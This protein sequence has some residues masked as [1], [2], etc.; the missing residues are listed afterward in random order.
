MAERFDVIV[1]GS[2]VNELT[3]ACYLAKAG[4]RVLVLDPRPEIGGVAAFQEI[5]PGFRLEVS[6]SSSGWFW[7]KIAKDLD[8]AV[9]QEWSDPTVVSLN[10]N[11]EPLVLWREM[12]RSRDEIKKHSPADAGKWDAFCALM[13]RLAGFLENLYTQSPPRLMSS[14]AVDLLMLVRLGYRLRQLGKVDMIELL[15]TLPMSAQDL[16]DHWFESELLKGTLGATG[17]TNTFQG[18]RSG[19]TCFV[20]LH[21]LVGRPAGAFRARTVLKSETGHLPSVLANAANRLGVEVRTGVAAKIAIEDGA[22]TGVVLDSGETIAARTV[23]SGADPRKTFLELCDPT[24]LGPEF[25]RAVKNVKMRGVRAMVHL[26]LGE[27][28]KFRGTPADGSLLRGV[29]SLSPSLDH[30]EHAYDDAKHGSVSAAPYLEATIPSLN[31]PGLAPAGKHVMSVAVQYT[32]YRLKEG[33]WDGPRAD[34]LADKVVATLT[35]YA[36]NLKGAIVGRRVYTPKDLEDGFGLT[37]GNLYGGELTLD[38]ILF[39]RPI[40][41]W[42]HYATPIQRLFLCG[43]SN[44]PGGALP[45]LAGANAAREIGKS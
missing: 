34:A 25:L 4:Q 39:M 43:D 2:G 41:G 44:H 36:P 7:P 31:D 24:E 8:L 37:E 11:G 26:A 21:H 10:P 13:H 3:A 1:V 30:L 18:P 29:V 9:S 12:E 19:G 35:E 22:A 27:L 40:P 5:C 45:G 42:A 38:Q 28:P 20:A 14:Q 15:R 6:P 33:A 32:P 23:I 16:L 17:V